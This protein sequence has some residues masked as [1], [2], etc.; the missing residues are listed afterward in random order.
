MNSRKKDEEEETGVVEKE[1]SKGKVEI[2]APAYSETA[3][4]TS[5]GVADP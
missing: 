3:A 4:D 5:C 1:K 2:A